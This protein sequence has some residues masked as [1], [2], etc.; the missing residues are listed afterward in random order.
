MYPY[1]DV[2]VLQLSMPTH[3]P[4][5][6]F[7]I[8]QQLQP[9]RE[10]GVLIIGSGYMT[11]GL[12]FLGRDSWERNVIPGWSRDFDAWAAEA[13]AAGRI[14]VLADLGHAPGM[15]YAHPTVEHYTPIFVTFGAATDPSIPPKVVIDDF[16]MGLAKRSFQVA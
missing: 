15:P 8:G 4:D 2:P 13:L 9:L 5:R 14:D 6:L 11:H 16:Q 1:A 3:D 10:E 7:R 12:P